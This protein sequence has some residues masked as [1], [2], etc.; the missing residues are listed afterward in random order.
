MPGVSPRWLSACKYPT[1]KPL[2]DRGSKL[3]VVFVWV[4]YDGIFFFVSK[5]KKVVG[6]VRQKTTLSWALLEVACFLRSP[7][8]TGS[9]FPLPL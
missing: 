5:K 3:S 4:Y 2:R 8:C 1:G 9:S 7:A 6:I